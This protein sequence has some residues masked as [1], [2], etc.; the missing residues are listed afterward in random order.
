MGEEMDFVFNNTQLSSESGKICQM[1]ETMNDFIFENLSDITLTEENPTNRTEESP[2]NST[3]EELILSTDESV[4]L[5]ATEESLNDC[6]LNNTHLSSQYVSAQI[7]QITENGEYT[8]ECPGCGYKSRKKSIIQKHIM[9]KHLNLRN[10]PCNECSYVAKNPQALDWHVS[11]VHGDNV[12]I[13]PECGFESK[14]LTSLNNHIKTVHQRIKRRTGG[15][16]QTCPYCDHTCDRRD[17]MTKHI[18]GKHSNEPLQCDKCTFKTTWQHV[19]DRH[20]K[21]LHEESVDGH[22]CDECSFSSKYSNSLV[23]HNFYSHRDGSS[24]VFIKNSEG[25]FKCDYCEHTSKDIS[26]IKRHTFKNHRN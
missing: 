7:F 20:I 14:W 8:C 6:G 12:H 11:G 3:E 26:G 19:L 1:N 2:K 15:R 9:A 21:T 5:E 25:H 10:H 24:F 4:K 13:C 23:Q 22:K 17:A 16:I 18:K